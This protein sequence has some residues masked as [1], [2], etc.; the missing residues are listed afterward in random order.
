MRRFM[1]RLLHAVLSENAR[2]R[3]RRLI[4][5][6]AREERR[7]AEREAKLREKELRIELKMRAHA[8]REARARRRGY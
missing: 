3:L 5:G 6:K 7:A 2:A 4:F 8:A 1:Y